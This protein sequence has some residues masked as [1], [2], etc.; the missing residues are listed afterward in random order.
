M[1]SMHSNTPGPSID[2]WEDKI[3][4]CYGD[5]CDQLAPSGWLHWRNTLYSRRFHT[6]VVTSQGLLLVG[7]VESPMTTE[8]LPW[9][10][11]ESRESFT[12]K[13]ERKFH[14]SI[15]P[16]PDTI[17]LM[18]GFPSYSL[19][20]EYSGLDA[21]EEVTSRELPPLLQPQELLACGCYSVGDSQ[22]TLVTPCPLPLHPSADPPGH[23]RS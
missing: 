6:S 15:H 18:G 20:T 2:S 11:G 10:G 9:E 23:R 22:V 3:I 19:V 4:A 21:G 8:L 12:L 13:H 14:C 17:V 7:G 1:S 5:T 16:G